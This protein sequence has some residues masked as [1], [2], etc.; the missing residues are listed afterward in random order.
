[1]YGLYDS[2]CNIACV[3]L[4]PCCHDD[5]F[6]YS[7]ILPVHHIHCLDSL[8]STLFDIDLV[9]R[10]SHGTRGQLDRNQGHDDPEGSGLPPPPTMAHVL[11]EIEK[12]HRDSHA[13]LEVIAR[14]STQ[15][16]NEMV[17]LKDFIH[18]HPPVFSYST[19]PLEADD[20]L[21]NIERKLQA[22]RVANGDKV[23]YAAYHLEGAA[24]SWWE[25]YLNMRPAGPPTVWNELC[26]AF[27]EH[28]IP[29]GLMDRKREEFCNLTQGRRTVDEFSREFN[30]LAR[31][32]TEEV[33]TDAN[34]QERFRRGLNS[35]LRRELN[36]HDFATF[37]VLVN[38]TIKAED[39]NTPN[40][41]RKHPREEGSSSSG[42]QKRKIWIPNS[43]FR[44]NNP[45]RPSYA[46][47]RPPTQFHPAPPNNPTPRTVFGACYK[48]GQ[49]GHYSR[50]CP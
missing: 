34:K 33:S 44:Q 43:M 18:L 7:V 37:Q 26:T 31:Y 41:F 10:M 12:N 27:R 1:M 5:Y 8:Q 40:D 4:S 38:K 49:A 25:N 30:R 39:M 23:N 47:P 36:L 3:L 6:L 48:C 20:W 16:R 22:G 28:H 21:R 14:N 13:L 17:C 2:F 11:M 46:A 45:P 29:K 42:S 50:E 9:L 19:E 15:Q 32:A 35:G 24:S